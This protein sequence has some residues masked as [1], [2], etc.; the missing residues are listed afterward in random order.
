MNEIIK[1]M[2]DRRSCRSYTGEQIKDEELDLILQAGVWAPSG[3]GAQSPMQV[4][5]QDPELVKK[6]SAMNAAVMG[7]D[8]DPFYGAPT[9][10]IVF[11]DSEKMT[12]VEDGA[13][14]LGNMMNAAASIG[15][16]SCWIHRARQ[17]FASE[18]GKALK[19]AWGVPD[20]Y[21]GIGHCILGYPA[22]ALPEG[23]PRKEG[24]IIKV[25]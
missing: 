9:V 15:V 17:V 6:L 2:M 5:V 18:E 22:A 24:R 19:K 13:L 7:S 25:G 23:K 1:N 8:A 20:S 12:Y 4:V 11:A 21:E 10:V 3:M 14:V 16:A